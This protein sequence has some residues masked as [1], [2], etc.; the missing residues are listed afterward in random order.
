MKRKPFSVL[1]H[2]FKMVGRNIRSYTMLS[3][4][5]ILSFSILLGFMGF[6]DSEHYNTYKK[7][8]SLDR[9]YIRLHSMS[10]SPTRIAQLQERAAEYGTTHSVQYYRTSLLFDDTGWMLPTG[11]R[12][13][14]SNPIVSYC[15]PRECWFVEQYGGSSTILESYTVTWLDGRDTNNISLEPGQIILDEQLYHALGF[16]PENPTIELSFHDY[17]LN[18]K[19]KGA[20]TAVG[21]IPANA[22]MEVITFENEKT[23]EHK[24]RILQGADSAYTPVILFSLDDLNPQSFETEDRWL[25]YIFF[26]SDQPENVHTMLKTMEPDAMIKTVYEDQARA[27]EQIQT[28]KGTKAI[29]AALLLVILGINLYSCFENALNDRKFEIG[30]KR[31]MGASGFS[32][33][34][35]FFYESMIVMVANIVISIAFVVDVGLLLKLYRQLTMKDFSGIVHFEFET[36]SLYITPYSIGMFAA[37]AIV[38]T[39]VFSLVFAYKTTQVQIVDYLKAE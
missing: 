12:L 6:M 35:Q 19:L 32:I 30:V 25:R 21:T 15:L 5:I 13:N 8:L 9:G 16:S 3:V 24:A 7:T 28:E 11:E 10:L 33:V 37:C 39:V 18:A 22:P 20:F 38:L 26:H 27:L 36:Y 14:S 34:R 17:N 1:R 31:A 23:G 4:T 2:A 29:I